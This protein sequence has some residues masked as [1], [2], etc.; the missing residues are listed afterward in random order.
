MSAFDTIKSVLGMIAPVACNL[1][2]PGSGSVVSGL[3]N[4]VMPGNDKSE[5]EKA[6]AILTDPKLMADL[7]TQAMDLEAKLAKEKT[8]MVGEV[9][10]TMR[11]ELKDGKWYQRAWRPFN[12]FLFPLTVILCYVVM[13]IWNSMHPLSYCIIEIPWELWVMWGGVLGVTSYGR[14]QEKKTQQQ[15]PGI[16]GTLLDKFRK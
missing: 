2:I 7:K 13:P 14:N 1:V 6:Q 16:L 12:G 8:A 3:L 5:E 4:T 9:N 10:T 15:A 11:A